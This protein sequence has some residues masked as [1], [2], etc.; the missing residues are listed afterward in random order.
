MELSKKNLAFIHNKE[1]SKPGADIFNLPEKI[2]QFGTG[3]L[4]RALP[5]YFVDKANRQGIFN[6]RILVIKSTSSG[7]ADV[8]DKQDGMYSLSIRGMEEAVP[9]DQHIICSAV[10]RVLSASSQ[11][12]E[13][14]E[15]AANRQLQ[16]V[17]SNTTEVGIQLVKESIFER[18]PASFPAKLL[19]FLFER[20]KIFK[21]SSD[22]G[23][24][25]I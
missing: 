12:A 18:P 22:A 13:I 17:I 14:L 6:G 15:S 11:W 20:Y 1:L 19:S 8:F 21:G 7:D 23:M 2:L 25:I 9:V 24:L 5:D 4:L 16:I 3:V 10:S